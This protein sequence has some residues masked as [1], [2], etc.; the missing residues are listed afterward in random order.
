[1]GLAIEMYVLLAL[2][3]AR[4]S[5][6]P[7]PPLNASQ[8]ANPELCGVNQGWV[9]PL[10]FLVDVNCGQGHQWEPCPTNTY[11]WVNTSDPF[12]SPLLNKLLQGLQL[13]NYRYPG[14][15]LGNGWDWH[16]GNMNPLA[17]DSIANLTREQLA[18]FPPNALGTA[19]FD[20]MTK[21]AGAKILFTLGATS[22][23]SRD[24]DATVPALVV[25]EIGLDRASR[26]EIGNEVYDPRAGPPPTGYLTAQDYLADTA[27]LLKAVHAV[28]ANAGVPVAPCPFFYPD[29][30][31]CWGGVTGRYH[32]W[33]RNISD[34]CHATSGEGRACPF[35]AVIAHN[36]AVDVNALKPYAPDQMMSVYLTIP[37]V[38]TDYGAAT[39]ARDFPGGTKLWLSEFNAFYAD[40]WGG[41]ADATAHD[42]A[43]FLNSTENSGA[44]AVHVASH[45][46]AGMAHP[47]IAVMNYHSFIEGVAPNN[48]GQ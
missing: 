37:Q 39:M 19:R 30:S 14:G 11:A 36:Y 8:P 17:N 38:T 13:G 22:R 1:M 29:G 35:E 20:A 46:I 18:K 23:W 10:G 6:R 33:N 15:G 21:R 27:D 28:G 31:P 24:H 26:W 45:I 48:L 43:A 12:N 42:A 4:A 2:V 9:D 7:P 34:A 40:V 25:S 44:H 32:K 41:K 5:G 16:T 47:V 3:G